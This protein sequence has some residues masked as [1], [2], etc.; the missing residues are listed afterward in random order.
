MAL[1]KLASQA[2]GE[3]LSQLLGAWQA[4]D[5]QQVPPAQE[6]GPRVASGVRSNWQQAVG[7]APSEVADTALLRLEMAAE[8]P[9][10][11]EHLE[12]RRR[13][14]LQLLTQRNEAPPAQ[15][16][17]QDVGSVLQS[18]FEPNTERRLRAALKILLKP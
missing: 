7:A 10:P 12:A 9:T 3:A 17:A 14:Q 11:A 16:W 13:F 8:V 18:G 15:T 5:P 1:R 4:R 2:H 6:F